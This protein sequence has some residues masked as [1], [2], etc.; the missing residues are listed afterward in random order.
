[1]N[2]NVCES[3]AGRFLEGGVCEPCAASSFKEDVS[4]TRCTQC[5]TS[6]TTRDPGSTAE[7]LCVCPPGRYKDVLFEACPENHVKPSFSNEA[8]T[9]CHRNSKLPAGAAADAQAQ[10]ECDPGFYESTTP[11]GEL[12][13]VICLA[14]TFSAAP[15]SAECSPCEPNTFSGAGS[16]G[17]QECGAFSSTHWE[18]GRD[19]CQCVV[20]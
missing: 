9:P 8:C 5:E 20:G 18:S 17:C 10:C 4:N 19:L 1:V 15:G 16:P 12:A 13:C 3:V 6:F 11:G 7:A 14:R 2:A